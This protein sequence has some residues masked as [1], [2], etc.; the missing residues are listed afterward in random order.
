MI[1][2]VGSAPRDA[3]VMPRNITSLSDEADS[4]RTEEGMASGVVEPSAGGSDGHSL[5]EQH[6]LGNTASAPQS[7]VRR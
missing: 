7:R 5:M 6:V 2:L 3:D 4:P 1:F